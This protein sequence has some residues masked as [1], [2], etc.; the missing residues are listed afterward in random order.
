MAGAIRTSDLKSRIMNVAQ[1]SVYQVKLQPPAE[2][3]SHLSGNNNFSYS[4]D[5][6]NVELMCE[7]TNLP[8]TSLSTHEVIGDYHGVRE[9]MAY[10]RMYDA[11]TDFTFYI[12]H[13]YKVLDF[14]DGWMDYISGV[15]N[16]QYLSRNSQKSSSANYRMN[17]PNNYMTNVY[18]SKFEKDVS[19]SQKIF[20]DDRTY[21]L[22][23]TFVQAFP[24]NIVSQPIAY[25]QSDLL[26]VTVSM[27]YQRYVREKKQVA[28]R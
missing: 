28:Q 7:A 23:Y 11:T 18:I 20:E 22:N 4:Q 15:G 19:S 1:T 8:G 14:F 2:V 12:D 9:R 24:L 5:G 10:R 3:V 16:G 13:D 25:A 26:R 27:A 17:Y 6:E 21:Y